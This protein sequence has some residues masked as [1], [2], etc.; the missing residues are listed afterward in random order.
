MKK[1]IFAVASLIFISTTAFCQ[2][3]QSL[4][5][6]HKEIKKEKRV[7]RR[8]LIRNEVAPESKTQFQNDFP[9]AS[10]VTYLHT[11][12]YDKI[13]FINSKKI[14][15]DA[16][17]DANHE[18]IGTVK[19]MAYKNIPQSLKNKIATK[20]KGY[21]ADNALFFDDNEANETDMILYE[22]T[23][24]DADNYFIEMHNGA[25]KIVVKASP[26][27]VISLFKKIK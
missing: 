14:K 6:S 2:N 19:N 9:G 1:I 3:A 13:S 7:I 20:F 11:G 16:F 24:D 23:F 18:L 5:D 12:Q 4:S 21:T 26:E 10:N 27:G 15:L 22:S 17:Y 25:G 8:D